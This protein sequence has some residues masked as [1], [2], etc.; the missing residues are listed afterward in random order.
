MSDEMVI[1]KERLVRI[2]D[3]LGALAG[4]Q[5]DLDALQVPVSADDEFAVFESVFNQFVEQ[6]AQ[7][8]LENEE[9]NQQRL[10][11]IERQRMAIADLSVPIIDVWQD[12]IM[13]PIVGIVDTQRSVEMTERL[14][15]R[16]A[17]GGAQCVIIDLTGVDVVD[18]ATADH[19]IRM[20][21]SVQLLG[22]FCVISGI[23][24]NIAQTLVQLEVDLREIAI[25][26][27]LREALKTCFRYLEHARKHAGVGVPSGF[28][29]P[30]LENGNGNGSA[31]NGSPR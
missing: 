30:G 24:P 25:V 20:L 4:G 2:A 29:I 28:A 1:P 16:V 8:R 26:R 19:L 7:M 12:V 13:L 3:T 6:F 10:E 18:T 21:R 27:N 14:L 31:G 15:G 17:N 11:I 9:L 23:S 5:A 22:S